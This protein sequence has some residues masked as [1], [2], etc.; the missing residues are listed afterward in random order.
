MSLTF[1]RIISVCPA[2][3]IMHRIRPFSSIPSSKEN[4]FAA[5]CIERPTRVVPPL[6]IIEKTMHQLHLKHEV[7]KSL[8]SDH[9]LRHFEDL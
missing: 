1:N 6:N 3:Q 9:E 8:Y 7:I 4:V 2:H 5:V